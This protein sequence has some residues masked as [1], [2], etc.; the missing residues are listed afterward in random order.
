M[1]ILMP[2]ET[3]DGGFERTTAHGISEI[4]RLGELP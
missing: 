3:K 1:P 2:T 4:L